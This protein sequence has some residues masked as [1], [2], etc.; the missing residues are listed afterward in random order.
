MFEKVT[1][2]D[3]F[4]YLFLI[5][6]HLEKC[7]CKIMR[8][9]NLS[10]WPFQ[11][12]ANRVPFVIQLESERKSFQWKV[13]PYSLTVWLFLPLS[14]LL[15]LKQPFKY[16]DTKRKGKEEDRNYWIIHIFLM[17]NIWMNRSVEGNGERGR[18]SEMRVYV[19]VWLLI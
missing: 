1:S 7:T 10:V 2:I 3:T 5:Y 14:S 15:I 12:S 6:S 18:Q 9:Q 4:S 16:E 11:Q 13:W 8:M 17:C 19:C